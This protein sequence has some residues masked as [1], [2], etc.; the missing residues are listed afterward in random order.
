[1]LASRFPTM[2]SGPFQLSFPP[3]SNLWQRHWTHEALEL[4]KKTWLMF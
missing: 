3:G 2:T 1:V 4:L